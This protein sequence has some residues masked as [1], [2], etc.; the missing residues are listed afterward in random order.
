MTLPG[1]PQRRWIKRSR[2][3][4]A[5]LGL[6][7]SLVLGW[8]WMA[9]ES[10]AAGGATTIHNRSA[11][12]YSQ[13]APG[14][15]PQQAAEHRQ[16]DR[17]FADVFIPA[18]A[19]FNAGLGPHFNNQSCLGCHIRDGRGQ[20]Q[21]GQL[22][23]RLSLP[24][25][26]GTPEQPGGAIPVPGLGSQLQD[27]SIPGVPPL[28]SF[29]LTWEEVFGRYADGRSY[30]LRRPQIQLLDGTGKALDPSIQVSLRLPPPV[31]GRGLLEA[32]PEEVL[33]AIADP[34]DRNHDGISGRLNQ[35]W[36]V[37]QQ[38]QAI[39][40]FGWKAGQPT[41]QQQNAAAYAH[42]MGVSNP[43]FPD[44]N[45]HQDIDA[46]TLTATTFYT[47]TLAV[48]APL[49]T[50][51]RQF[52]QGFALF[53]DAGCA[54]C[55]LPKLKTGR[56]SIAALSEQTFAPYTDLLLHDL[57]PGLADQ[58]PEFLANGQ[59][60]RT[61]PLWGLGLSQTVLPGATYLHDGRARTIAEAILWHG[62]EAES[63]REWF[64]T[65]SARDR[66]RLER[67]LK[68]L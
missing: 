23:A 52:R 60:W 28:G 29:Q 33:A 27:H 44:A 43:L 4:W 36:D 3:S 5:G 62:G 2:L 11:R 42:D 61:A 31:F 38:K 22:L 20:P 65:A 13:P 10:V 45:G 40:R 12:A 1:I 47:Q 54:A 16:G 39:G 14:L 9:P 24:P 66:K 57:G 19:T 7:L 41:L 51:D 63:A 48:P 8:W 26:R 53:Q 6:I 32:V 67:F 50:D 18:P 59:E 49:R 30:S 56:S 25:D 35:V 55:H 21:A 64:R 37:A 46:Q 15:N 58:R 17:R 68:Q 34:E